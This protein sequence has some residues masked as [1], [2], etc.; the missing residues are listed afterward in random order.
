MSN[1]SGRVTSIVF[2]ACT[3]HGDGT[4]KEAGPTRRVVDAYSGPAGGCEPPVL[5]TAES[6][7]GRKEVRRVR[8][9][10]MR[11]KPKLFVQY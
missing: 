5:P 2:R 9:R 6:D 4:M 3:L 7:P 1:A 8:G 10:A 11:L